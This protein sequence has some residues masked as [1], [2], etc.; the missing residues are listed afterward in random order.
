MRSALSPAAAAVVAAAA[1][2]AAAASAAA[3]AAIDDCEVAIIG[4]GIGGAYTAW[5]LA[6]D[7]AVVPA[8]SVC[9]FEASDR[10]GGRI[11]SV[12]DV[13]GYEGFVTD[14][15]AY[16]FHRQSHPIIRSL[17]EDA[18]GM[19][20][21]CY[22]DPTTTL[23]MDVAECPKEARKFLTVRTVSYTGDLD[24]GKGPG[25][26]AWSPRVPFFL[27]PE[28]RW[29]NGGGRKKRR[30]ISDVVV[31]SDSLIPEL[32]SRW[33]AL[34]DKNSTFE[35]TMKLADEAL[36]A[37]RVGTY[38]GIPYSDVSVLQIARD[39]GLTPE[40]LAMEVGFASGA[41]A[42][43]NFNVLAQL[44]SSIRS[45]ATRRMKLSAKAP[46]AAMVV[47]VTG[48]GAGRKRAGMA[49][50]ITKMLGQAREAGVRVYTGH[51]AV[52]VRQASRGQMEVDFRNG[53]TVTAGRLFLNMG[54]AD[55]LALGA[56]SEP[57]ASA[58]VDA[59]RRVDAALP[60]GASKVYCYWPSAWWLADLRLSAGDAKTD[61]PSIVAPRYHDGP[62]QCT[63]P[64][65]VSTCRG[66]L[67]VSYSW[68]DDTQAASGL[69]GASH[70]D[71]PYSPT[72]STGPLT[73]FAKGDLT[74]RQRLGWTAIV[75]GLRS[76]HAPILA[77]RNLSAAI[78]PEPDVCIMASWFDVS[79]HIHR[80]VTTLGD[81]AAT[82]A[83]AQPAPG[84]PVHLVNEAWGDSHGWAEGSLQSAERALWAHMKVPAPE[85]LN[86]LLHTAVIKKFNKGA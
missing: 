69:W 45:M 28:E 6:V 36:A 72:S 53:V 75:D 85:W 12:D 70:A 79:L 71:S 11:Y 43:S 44:T 49:S 27:S 18:L 1:I 37:L 41:G 80:A 34:Q 26:D 25:L 60:L 22:T 59:R 76:S 83:F 48:K 31:G 58:T 65:D 33:D 4:G 7:A 55:L 14:V 9:L 84:L 47:P 62:V 73:V 21:A 38:K 50:I 39:A 78:I 82:E 57:M 64:A 42:F 17:T 13:P 67:L 24:A 19:E 56:A 66:G 68:G 10:F 29:G 54:K 86:P 8:A 35:A 20:T 52:A 63:D 74:P 32:A 23:P 15:G 16:R 40:E 3:V 61:G 77:A 2:S 46:A 5:R 51:R 81:G 30:R